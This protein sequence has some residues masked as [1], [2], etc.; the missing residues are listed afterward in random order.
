MLVE[1]NRTISDDDY[2]GWDDDQYIHEH[3]VYKGPKVWQLALIIVFGILIGSIVGFAVGM[4]T[5]KRFNRY[6]RE[7]TLFRPIS[8]TRNSFVR[9][10][11][12]LDK[13]QSQSTP[14]F[15]AEERQLLGK[16]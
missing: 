10:S 6:V 11:L 13:M 16:Y 12:A 2:L 8:K 15:S 9:S 7:S 4:H 1:E 3:I 5:N 14:Q